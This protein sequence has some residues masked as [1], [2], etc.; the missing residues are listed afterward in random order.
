MVRIVASITL[1]LGLTTGT[2][3]AAGKAVPAGAEME[4]QKE[5]STC[6]MAYP[7]EMLPV[8]SWRKIMGNLA[9]HFG[10]NATLPEPSRADIEAYLITN[11]GDAPGAPD[12]PV[13][14]NDIPA[15]ATP[16]RITDTPV[17]NRVHGEV[18]E[19]FFAS[20]KVKSKANCVA[21]HNM[22]AGQ[23]QNGG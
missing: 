1:A 17:W 15:D 23:D 3:V 16:L 5:C 18:P 8:R 10:E 4:T 9:N 13:F 22:A 2:A 12:G 20:S 21:C 6:H 11:A 19:S 7:P 14:V